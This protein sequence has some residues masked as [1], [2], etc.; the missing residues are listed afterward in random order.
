MERSEASRLKILSEHVSLLLVLRV[1][2]INKGTSRAR[3]SQ[4]TP[5]E[6]RTKGTSLSLSR[7]ERLVVGS[8]SSTHKKSCLRSVASPEITSRS[9]AKPR[10]RKALGK[11]NG[12]IWIESQYLESPRGWHDCKTAGLASSSNGSTVL[13]FGLL[14]VTSM[15]R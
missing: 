12:G 1:V 5:E 2:S 11:K 8:C 4:T 3:S 9:R 10:E 14:T 7:K 13:T 15:V 6:P